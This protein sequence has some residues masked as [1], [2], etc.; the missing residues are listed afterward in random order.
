[1]SCYGSL[2]GEFFIM[3]LENKFGNFEGHLGE[4]GGIWAEK[5][6]KNMF[7]FTLR[8]VLLKTGKVI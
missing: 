5:T 2:A 6:L 1:M 4:R 7:T 3:V 8:Y